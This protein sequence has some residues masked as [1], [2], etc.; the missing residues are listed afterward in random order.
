[1]FF[2]N[3]FF[4][5]RA[6]GVV[7]FIPEVLCEST[8]SCNNPGRGWYRIVYFDAA[9]DPREQFDLC[10][11][12][13]GYQL[14]LV[15]ID[16]GAFR[17][18]RISA[19][20]CDH[21]RT[22]LDWYREK[23]LQVILRVVYD[24]EGKAPEREPF[25]FKQVVEHMQQI[26]ELIGEYLPEIF[27]YQGLL[28]GNWGEM[29]TSRF[30]SREKL[31]QLSDLL[32]EAC[33]G[34]TLAVRKPAQLRLLCPMGAKKPLGEN[35]RIG[36]FNDGIL[37][38]ETDLGTYGHTTGTQVGWTEA[39]LPEEE[40]AFQ[41]QLGSRVPI[42]GEA[43]YPKTGEAPSLEE[44]VRRLSKMR[45][46]YLNAEYDPRLLCRWKETVWTKEDAWK[47]IDGYTYIGN[48]LGYRYTLREIGV[49]TLRREPHTYLVQGLVE[50]VGFG[51]IYEE[52]ALVLS[53]QDENGLRHEDRV[54]P[55]LGAWNETGKI[56]FSTKLHRPAGTLSLRMLRVRD[57]RRIYFANE[58]E[59]EEG[60]PAGRFEEAIR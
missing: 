30:L 14:E 2:Q 29:H 5:G 39:W 34:L 23:G 47:G 35:P 10:G 57:G 42:G 7:N 33:D 8:N 58:G 9:V 20:G 31:G 46:T 55:D 48:H 60:L 4:P 24:H 3:R 28:V 19:E 52:T 38:S 13:M 41:E 36:L 18:E 27:V 25:L 15:V 6:S 22:I 56:K 26:A 59:K 44:T 53:W 37:G 50:N 11:L 45:L 49:Q 43:L 16:I 21:I 1:M 51:G 32:L 54:V 12:S 17:E 40:L